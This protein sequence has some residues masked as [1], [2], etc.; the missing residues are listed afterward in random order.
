[1]LAKQ[2]LA[3]EVMVELAKVRLQREEGLVGYLYVDGHVR[4]YSGQEDL[5][6]T[7]S[8]VRHVPVAATTDTWVADRRGDPVLLV[9]SQVNEHL[10]QTLEPVL[11]D[12]RGVIGEGTRAT[13]IFDRGGWS[14]QL[15]ARLVEEGFDII[16]Y[17]KGKSLDVPEGEFT[18]VSFAPEGQQVTYWL[19]DR[20]EVR[21]GAEEVQWKDGK[22]SPL[23]MRQVTR[24][25]RDSGHQTKALTTRP[26]LLT[27]RGEVLAGWGV[28]ISHVP[29]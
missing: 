9:T 11:K 8:T 12:V 13:V 6:K 27:R 10:T 25:N 1:L 18:K 21:V 17:R 15:F 19:H 29:F 20:G 26:D 2:E 24:L 5:A 28:D 3:R 14:A 4:E 23:W 22:T 7:Y 16:T